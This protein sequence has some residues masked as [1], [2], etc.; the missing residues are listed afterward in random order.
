MFYVNEITY[1]ANGNEIERSE[2]K[3]ETLE[4]ARSCFKNLS[5]DEYMHFAYK[6]FEIDELDGSFGVI[7]SEDGNEID[8]SYYI[9]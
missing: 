9:G 8:S 2:N 3:Y 7:L 6:Q 1:D 5:S 4:E